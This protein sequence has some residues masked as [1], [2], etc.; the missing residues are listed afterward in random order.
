MSDSTRS[1]IL[2]VMARAISIDLGED[3]D[4]LDVLIYDRPGKRPHWE[5]YESAAEASLAHLSAKGMAVVPGWQPIESAPKDGTRIILAWGGAAVTGSYLD[6]GHTAYP[7]KG[8]RVPSLEL[9]PPGAPVAW[10]PFPVVPANV[11]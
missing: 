1:R 4:A 7:W 3:P 2:E 9:T 6:N 8:W 11:S 5:G 10:M